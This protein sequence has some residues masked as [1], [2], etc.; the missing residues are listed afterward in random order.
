MKWVKTLLIV[1]LIIPLVGLRAVEI[2]AHRGASYD[3]PEN[4]L[5][6][7]RLG[8]TQQADAVELDIRL[9]RDGQIV[10]IHD[11]NT[12][13][14]TGHDADVKS[15]SLASL[16]ALDAGRW[17]G[18]QWQGERLPTL[19]E[20]LA[21]VPDGK[22]LFI[23]IKCGPEVLPELER[24]LKTAGKASE[25][26]VLIGFK[27]ETMKTARQRFPK[28]PL[29]W[30]VAVGTDAK[31]EPTPDIETLIAKA[32]AAGFDGLNLHYRFPIDA[33]A[34]AKVRAAG[35]RLYVWTVDDT[36][37]AARLAAVGVNGLTTNRPRWLRDQLA[38]V[39]PSP[40]E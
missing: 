20:A 1:W 35:L 7:F 5:A 14:T 34:V 30:L 9:T 12:R 39:R 2:I 8:Y 22:Q 26:T 25:Q 13:R 23:E 32:R 16:R 29:Y 19:S 37:V 17:K 24:V 6:A 27:Y 4:T 31:T 36:A 11:A 33:A 10:V 21:T 38:L 3:A 28:L 40:G 15:C 18:A